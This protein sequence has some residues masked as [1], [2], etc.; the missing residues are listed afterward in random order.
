MSSEPVQ[1]E[2]K[3]DLRKI[4]ADLEALSAKADGVGEH[5]NRSGQD[6]E[7]NLARNTKDVE[8]M[9]EHVRDLGRRMADQIRG[10]FADLATH[11]MHSLEDARKDLGLKKQFI[12]A[13]K[14]AI[15]FN[16]VLHKI[17]TTL[18]MNSNQ[19][20]DFQQEATGAFSAIGMDAD[21]AARALSGVAE[22][23]VRGKEN[24]LEVAKKGAELSE[25]SGQKGA[26]GETAKGLATVQQAAGRD[27]NNM[28]EVAAL[29]EDVRHIYNNTGQKPTDTLNRMAS[30]Y[31]EMAPEAKKKITSE[32]MSKLSSV[33]A[34]VG[35]G[36]ES[37][38]KQL[39][40]GHLQ[41]LP[42]EAQG[43]GGI[44]GNKGVDFDKLKR[45]EGIGNRIPGDRV[46]SFQTT[47]MDKD[48]AK[49]L[50][51]LID[52]AKLAKAAQDK[53]QKDIPGGAKSV[54]EQ[55][56]QSRGLGENFAATKNQIKGVI[57]KIE[58][59]IIEGANKILGKASETKLGSAAVI[60]GGFLAMT[61][62][63]FGVEHLAKSLSKKSKAGGGGILNDAA[64]QVMAAEKAATVEQITG[65]KTMPVYVVNVAELA[66]AIGSGG[67][68]LGGGIGGAAGA[69]GGDGKGGAFSKLGKG[70]AIA[71]TAIAAFETVEGLTQG[72]SE[73]TGIEG[74]T[75]TRHLGDAVDFVT[76]GKLAAAKAQS[77]DLE[78]QLAAGRAK[79]NAYAAEQKK[80]REHDTRKRL[81]STPSNSRRGPPAAAPNVGGR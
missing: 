42:L 81:D 29:A 58:A 34:V 68:G 15:N 30:L 71:G 44:I 80:N 3:S 39:T 61:A 59:P 41:N 22:T 73:R 31:G 6:V 28:K 62:A 78:K 36:F 2:V 1:V 75:I 26:E 79:A 37:L 70:V 65:Q 19:I 13:T 76:G 45:V 14:E 40:A 8:T 16:S 24:I 32:G 9:L 20:A 50:V 60:G 43:F 12:D 46:A 56:H 5:L 23:Q 18:G 47:G 38:V 69:L 33:E 74:G 4:I 52:M 48:A 53:S 17:G 77:D 63:K 11:T 7:K 54:E 72:K 57:G 35:P 51:Q 49:A 67:N 66:T 10:Y 21:A 55:A 64:D 27:P 25:M